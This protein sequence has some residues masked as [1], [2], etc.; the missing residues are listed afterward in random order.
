M[1][2][3]KQAERYFRLGIYGAEFIPTI[4]RATLFQNCK[5]GSDYID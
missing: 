4:C 1:E 3:R 2:S 5:P